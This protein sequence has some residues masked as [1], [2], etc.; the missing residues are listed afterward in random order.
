MALIQYDW[1]EKEIPNLIRFII[2]RGDKDTDR[3]DYI[4][5]QGENGHLQAKQRGHKIN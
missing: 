3:K 5:T 2:R 4:K 1:E